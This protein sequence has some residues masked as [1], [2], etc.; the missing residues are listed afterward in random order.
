MRASCSFT[1]R[2]IGAAL[3]ASGLGQRLHELVVQG[4]RLLLLLLGLRLERVQL[5]LL[6]LQLR[7]AWAWSAVGLLLERVGLSLERVGLGLELRRLGLEL[8]LLRLQRRRLLLE[9]P[10]L[11]Q[12]RPGL[13]PGRASDRRPSAA[14]AAW[15]RAQPR[16]QAGAPAPVG[17]V[18][19][20]VLH[21]PLLGAD[22][23]EA[24]RVASDVR[25]ERPQ[26][27]P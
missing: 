20:L 21:P 18:P 17:R 2:G 15:S 27:R 19:E 26:P 5:R 8:L 3:V 13:P 4:V 16:L 24:R 6:L 7:A 1:S 23:H 14:R 9:R 22:R 25:R 12:E 10:R 11:P